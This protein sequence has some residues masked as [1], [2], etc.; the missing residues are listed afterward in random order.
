MQVFLTV[1]AIGML[2]G[3]VQGLMMRFGRWCCRF[4]YIDSVSTIYTYL[5]TALDR[6]LYICTSRLGGRWDRSGEGRRIA[7]VSA[8]SDRHGHYCTVQEASV[9]HGPY[10]FLRT[11][12]RYL[13]CAMCVSWYVVKNDYRDFEVLAEVSHHFSRRACDA[14]VSF[15]HKYRKGYPYIKVSRW[16]SGPPWRRRCPCGRGAAK[17]PAG[18]RPPVPD[19]LKSRI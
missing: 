12:T 18:G 3:Q 14:Y 2:N 7:H 1:R 5:K 17:R 13:N 8:L 15:R 11:R 4:I 19:I 10:E 6:N 9:L 16:G